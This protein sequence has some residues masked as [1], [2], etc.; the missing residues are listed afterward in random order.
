MLAPSRY[1]ER[2]IHLPALD[3]LREICGRNSLAP[4]GSGLLKGFGFSTAKVRDQHDIDLRQ[5]AAFL[6]QFQWQKI[7]AKMTQSSG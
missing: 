3:R 7:F 4:T 5:G 1:L 6:D 2:L